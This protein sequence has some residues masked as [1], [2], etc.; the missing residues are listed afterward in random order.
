MQNNYVIKTRI[1]LEIQ[2]QKFFIKI[3]LKRVSLGK[4]PASVFLQKN[5]KYYRNLLFSGLFM[6]GCFIFYFIVFR[7]YT[8]NYILFFDKIKLQRKET[9]CFLMNLYGGQSSVWHMI[10]TS[11]AVHWRVSAVWTRRPL[12]NQNAHQNTASP[13]G[14]QLKQS[15]KY[16]MQHIQHF[17]NSHAILMKNSIY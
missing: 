1:I 15:R 4:I 10:T 8:L 6:F 16:W 13:D 2:P 9:S 7:Y 11:V 3:H 14:Y 5:I 12:I 17:H